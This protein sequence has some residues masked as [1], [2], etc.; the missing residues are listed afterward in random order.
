LTAGRQLA[1]PLGVFHSMN[2]KTSEIVSSLFAV[3]ASRTA[4]WPWSV[5]PHIGF[6][7]AVAE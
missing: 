4:W 5:Q 6:I 2:L 1:Q 7:L 3:I